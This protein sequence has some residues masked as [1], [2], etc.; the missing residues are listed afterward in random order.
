M[1]NQGQERCRLTYDSLYAISLHTCK[2]RDLLGFF[3]LQRMW[4][5]I[6]LIP[7]RNWFKE[8]KLVASFI[9]WDEI[10]TRNESS[11]RFLKA[12]HLIDPLANQDSTKEKSRLLFY[13][14]SSRPQ[15]ASLSHFLKVQT[16]FSL[17]S[18]CTRKCVKESAKRNNLSS[19][20]VPATGQ[21]VQEPIIDVL[22]T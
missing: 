17:C 22:A 15:Y 13:L 1:R 4:R 8:A 10:V 14:A 19:A 9:C 3:F 18:L 2:K 12:R 16:Y 7:H 6:Q 20:Q 21:C 11:L 5:F